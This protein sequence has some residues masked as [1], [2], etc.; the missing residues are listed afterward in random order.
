MWILALEEAARIDA[1]LPISVYHTRSVT[2]KTGR[3]DR[4]AQ[5]VTSWNCQTRRQLKDF[6][7]PIGEE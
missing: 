1:D 2:N 7:T 6:I 3:L 5:K 4:F